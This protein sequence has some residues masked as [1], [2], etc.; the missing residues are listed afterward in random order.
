MIN[1]IF[2]RMESLPMHM[3]TM[4]SNT[5]FFYFYIEN[6]F[7]KYIMENFFIIYSFHSFWISPFFVVGKND[8]IFKIYNGKFFCQIFYEKIF[9]A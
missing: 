4:I 9:F 8:A 6:F 5:K 7:L 3:D 1:D 2:L